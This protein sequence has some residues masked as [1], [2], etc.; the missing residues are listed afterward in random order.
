MAK[1]IRHN[2]VRTASQKQF[3]RI[4]RN[5]SKAKKNFAKQQKKLVSMHLDLL[6]EKVTKKHEK[7]MR[8]KESKKAKKLRIMD[9]ENVGEDVLAETVNNENIPASTTEKNDEVTKDKEENTDK[10]GDVA[11]E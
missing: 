3:H 8:Q 9:I 10:D 2:K 6:D 1:G 7:K 5:K 4:K 11:M